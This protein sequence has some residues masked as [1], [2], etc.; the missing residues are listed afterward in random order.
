[1]AAGAEVDS[2]WTSGC[3][4][5]GDEED[6]G[7]LEELEGGRRRRGSSVAEEGFTGGRR[8]RGSPAESIHLGV[9]PLS[10]LYRG[11]GNGRLGDLEAGL[12]R[13]PSRSP[14]NFFDSRLRNA[15][16]R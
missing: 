8:R 4:G 2:I 13:F 1:M 3:L 16:R 14:P 12:G 6:D 5:G 7:G 11:V 9:P 10:P 15:Q